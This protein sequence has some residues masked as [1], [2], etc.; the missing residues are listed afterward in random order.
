MPGRKIN[1]DLDSTLCANSPGSKCSGHT[2]APFSSK[3]SEM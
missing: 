1:H 3:G 2:C